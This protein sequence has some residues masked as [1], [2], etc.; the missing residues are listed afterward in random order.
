MIMESPWIVERAGH[1]TRRAEKRH[2]VL[3]AA[4]LIFAEQGFDK[5]S[6]DDIAAALGVTKPTL[7]K[8]FK[9]KADLLRACSSE[10]ICRYDRA[11]SEAKAHKG[12][13]LDKL[14]LYLRRSVEYSTDEL[15]RALV[16][17]DERDLSAT[18][19][20]DRKQ[21]RSRVERMFRGIVR[22]GINNGEIR[23]D[24]DPKVVT[25]ALFGTFNNIAIWYK[26]TGEL[27]LEE[28]VRQ[29][30]VVLLEG[31]KPRE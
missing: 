17:I 18:G 31:L 25:F 7:Y 10:A 1:E 4:A 2:A 27:P 29:Y 3:R 9:D 19:R 21:L 13:S 5:T 16:M 15:G 8:Y 30:F 6:M 26:R 20:E 23:P 28:I 22:Q 14:A 12:G 24:L 11:A